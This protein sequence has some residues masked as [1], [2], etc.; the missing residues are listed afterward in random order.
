MGTLHLNIWC[1][2]AAVLCLVCDD[3][4][5]SHYNVWDVNIN[6]NELNS[7]PVYL[8]VYLGAHTGLNLQKVTFSD[9]FKKKQN[10]K[11]NVT[12]ILRISQAALYQAD[13]W[14]LC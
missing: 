5:I 4:R 13:R 14:N 8:L 1:T 3:F 10:K 11:K 12:G 9:V 6:V 2:D 7:K